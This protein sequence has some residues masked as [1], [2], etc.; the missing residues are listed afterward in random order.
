[1]KNSFYNIINLFLICGI[2]VATFYKYPDK[3]KIDFKKQI[4]D[5]TIYED[6]RDL[7]KVLTFFEFPLLEYWQH[8][9]LSKSELKKIY[10]SYWERFGYSK[11]EIQKIDKITEHEFVLTTN[12]IFK[13]SIFTKLNRYR[14]SETKFRFNKS[15]KITS[16]INLKLKKIDGQYIIDNNLI[17]NFSYAENIPQ[18]NNLQLA[19]VFIVLLI[20]NLSIQIVSFINKR[21]RIDSKVNKSKIE[22]ESNKEIVIKKDKV[23]S[24]QKP[25]EKVIKIN[26]EQQKLSDERELNRLIELE[27]AQ[28]KREIDLREKKAAEV[29]ANRELFTRLEKERIEREKIE[30]EKKQAA[31]IRKNKIAKEQR[32]EKKRIEKE[33]IKAVQKANAEARRK[34]ENIVIQKRQEKE[35]LKREKEEEE[36]RKNNVSNIVLEDDNDEFFD[37]TLSQFITEIPDEEE[38]DEEIDVSEFL[39]EKY[40]SKDLKKKFKNR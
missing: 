32:E 17:S 35:K 14:L 36:E 2:L 33:K 29:K 1:V 4:V 12:Y 8:K 26:I 16:I 37:N 15:G 19:F 13:K 10:L 30:A 21:K 25:Q 20:L 27:E 40:L 23:K 22:S 6:A 18:K 38:L 3:N 5:F 7:D 31:R 34:K 39:T 28:K 11:N 9:K 24:N